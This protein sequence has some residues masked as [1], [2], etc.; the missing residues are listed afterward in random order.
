[1]SEILRACLDANCVDKNSAFYTLPNVRISPPTG[2]L[3][4]FGPDQ[5]TLECKSD[6]F[7]LALG[8]ALINTGWQLAS[9]PFATAE[10]ADFRFQIV[11]LTRGRV[12]ALG[13]PTPRN[14]VN[15]D[16]NNFVTMPQSV[17]FGPSDLLQSQEIVQT[18]TSF[19]NPL[20][21]YTSVV[22]LGIEYRMRN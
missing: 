9:G 11:N 7:F 13:G 16:L 17:L 1:M 2:G 6:C 18:G 21:N 5:V 4:T 10:S 15:R 3:S 12:Y 19:T 8:W 22:I 20:T 14:N